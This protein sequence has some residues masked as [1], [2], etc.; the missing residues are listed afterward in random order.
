MKMTDH[1]NGNYSKEFNSL[2]SGWLSVSVL[3]ATHGGLL[4]EYFEN[5]FLD[6]SAAMSR[7]DS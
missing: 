4:G 1:A 2:T 5:I 3:L 6:G 7:V